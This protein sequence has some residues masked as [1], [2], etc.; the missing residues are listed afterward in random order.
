MQELLCAYLSFSPVMVASLVLIFSHSGYQWHLTTNKR[1][2]AAT[3]NAEVLK[4]CLVKCFNA[5]VNGRS[6]FLGLEKQAFANIVSQLGAQV[7][8]KTCLMLSY[9]K[10]V[11]SSLKSRYLNF[12]L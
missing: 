10:K 11:G 9:Q 12:S 3:K 7:S 2:L 1:H 6:K 5:L 4:L 8:R